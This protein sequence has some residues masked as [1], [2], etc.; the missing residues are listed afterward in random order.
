MEEGS[1]DAYNMN[2]PPTENYPSTEQQISPR[3]NKGVFYHVT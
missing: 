3:G 1:L 2:S